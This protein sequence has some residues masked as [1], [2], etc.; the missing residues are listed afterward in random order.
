MASVWAA[1]H[2]N[3][4]RVAIKLLHPELSRDE[5]IRARFLREGYVANKVQHQRRHHPRRRR[6]R[7]S[8]FLVMEL[9]EGETLS[10]RWKR[11]DRRLAPREVLRVADAVLDVLAAAHDKGIVHRDVKPAN[12]FL[13]T[14][15]R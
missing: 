11:H 2:R 7:G 8:V 1:R 9:L 10:E 6:R 12:I 13:T 15:A 5:R 3:G 4:K 14:P